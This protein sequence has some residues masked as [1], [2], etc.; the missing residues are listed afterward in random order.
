MT[1]AECETAL[2]P[3]GRLDVTADNRGIVRKW[4]NAQGF[5]SLFT[6]GLSMRELAIAYNQADGSGIANLKKKLAEGTADDGETN[7]ADYAADKAAEMRAFPP[8]TAAADIVRNHDGNPRNASVTAS[9]AG[10]DMTRVTAAVTAAL[11]AMGPQVDQAAIEKSVLEA[12]AAWL[13]KNSLNADAIRALVADE[14]PKHVTVHR[15]ELKA[16]NGETKAIEGTV[17]PQFATLLKAATSRMADGFHPNIWL[18]GPAG[19]GKTHAAKMLAKALDLDFYHNGALSM[20]HEVTGFI[21]AAGTYHATAF[22]KGYSNAAVYLF[23]E[24]DGSDNSPLLALN[25][26]LANGTA[27]FPDD[28][29]VTRHKDS[30]IIATANTWGQGATAEYVGRAKIDSAFLSRFPVK[31]AWGYDDKFEQATCG[32]AEWAKRVQA[33]RAKAA[34]AGLKVLIDPRHSIAGAALIAQGFTTQETA[35]LTYLAGLKPEQVKMLEG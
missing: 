29:N 20:S 16:A 7:G 18:A 1:P 9:A 17:H 22:R 13:A 33:A 26:G 14:A 31:I 6:S 19:S 12:C 4:L 5:P 8:S 35:E 34:A 15:V 23:D 25:A 27:S 10:P 24:C 11:A 30:I 3:R 32:N 28:Y 2:G 21:D